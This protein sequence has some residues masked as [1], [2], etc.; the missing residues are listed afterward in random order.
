MKVI[1]SFKYIY[2]YIKTDINIC[3]LGVTSLAQ[4]LKE[5]STL[6]ELNLLGIKNFFLIYIL[7]LSKIK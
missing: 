1:K 3:I 4:A 2:R 5:N 6:V 7:L